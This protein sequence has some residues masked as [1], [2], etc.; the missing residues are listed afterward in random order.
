AFAF[1]EDVTKRFEAYGWHTQ[2][3]ADG[4][5]VEAIEKAIRNAQESDRPSLIAV[6]THIGYGSPHKQDNASSHGSPL[7]AEEVKLTKQVYGWPEEPPFY[8]PDEALSHFREALDRGSEWENSWNEMF[9]QF[10][11]E[12][13]ELAEELQKNWDRA[14]PPDIFDNL[15]TW[16]PGNSVATRTASGKVLN[17][18]A[19]QLPTLLGGSADLGPS[20]DTQIFGAEDFEPETPGGRNIHFGVREHAMG[21]ALNGM[22]LHGGVR[23]Y[24]GTFLIFSDYMRPAIRLAALM[25]Q[26]AIYIFTHDSIGLGEDGPTHQPIEQL[27]SL[28]AMPN[29]L[30]LR[31][32]DANETREAWKV[33][34]QSCDRPVA[35]ALTR[36]KVP[37]LPTDKT[38]GLEHGAYILEEPTQSPNVILMASGSEV[39]VALEAAHQLNQQGNFTRV[40]S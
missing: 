20:N 26:P 7:G 34:I 6:R 14:L 17:A 35:L 25:R 39:S 33:A 12:N 37:T 8:I 4:N 18:L 3:I 24:G 27:P 22:L 16:E 19:A 1:D 30:V 9:S 28:R 23:V 21:S 15:P 32:A 38:A 31:P 36:Q 10:K 29:L 5:D 2:R 40:V 13:S 11:K